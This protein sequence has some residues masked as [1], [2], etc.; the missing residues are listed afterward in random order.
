METFKNFQPV[1]TD[2]FICSSAEMG[3]F[4]KADGCPP[5]GGYREYSFALW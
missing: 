4:R 5:N 1:V 2:V 3:M